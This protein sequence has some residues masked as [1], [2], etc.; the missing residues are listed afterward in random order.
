M[1]SDRILTPDTF[2]KTKSNRELSTPIYGSAGSSSYGTTGDDVII[3]GEVVPPENIPGAAE[4]RSIANFELDRERS[5]DNY[6]NRFFKGDGPLGTITTKKR[7]LTAQVAEIWV[8][9]FQG[10]IDALEDSGY[11]IKTLLGYCKRN[12]GRSS[13]WSTH[14]SGAA[15]DI[16]PPN[17]V[18]RGIPNGLFSP[19]PAD[20]P[21][22][23][24]P[25]GTG[26][27]AKS[28]GLGWGGA[29][30]SIDDA[31]HFSVA[32]NE[33]G[34]YRIVPGIIPQGPST[35]QQI[36]DEGDP[37]G[38]DYYTAPSKEISEEEAQEAPTEP[39]NTNDPG[40]QNADGTSNVQ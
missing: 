23:D 15:I 17:P 24:M 25:E 8:P 19:R 33:G 5:T 18:Q 14:A 40:P 34:N 1:P 38:S 32:A 30:T 16:N 10:F 13:N 39:E 4:L 28:F 29:W 6:C 35:D 3:N 21:I 20:A 12:I 2:T 11:T 36:H 22:T 31:M 37:R 27:L 26:D 7:G 9:N